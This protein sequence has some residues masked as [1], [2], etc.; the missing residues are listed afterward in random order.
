M[1]VENVETVRQ[2]FEDFNRGDVEDVV[3]MCDRAIEWFPPS[4]LPGGG[5][6]HGHEGVRAAV[7]VMLELFGSLQAK[8]ERLIDAGDRVVVLFRWH[9]HGKGS[10]LSLD[11]FGAQAAVFT[12]R[13]GKVIRVEWYLDKSKDL[14][15]AGLSEQDSRAESS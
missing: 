3:E 9:G 2:G 8:P 13:D 10:G 12:M 5:A 14:E 4:Q 6:Y 11:H 7:G 1:S 15:A